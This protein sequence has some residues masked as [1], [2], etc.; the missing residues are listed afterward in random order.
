VSYVIEFESHHNALL[1]A[2]INYYIVVMET[3]TQELCDPRFY[4]NIVI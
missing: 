2:L 1:F 4:N 3:T